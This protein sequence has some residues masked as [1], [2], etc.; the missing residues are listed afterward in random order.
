LNELV[1][2]GDLDAG[3]P[4]SMPTYD[5]SFLSPDGGIQADLEWTQAEAN[6]ENLTGKD[7]ID[8]TLS[9]CVATNGFPPFGQNHV[10]QPPA[11]PDCADAGGD[12]VYLVEDTTPPPADAAP[13]CDPRFAPDTIAA[14]LTKKGDSGNFT[15]VM[16]SA[17][18]LPPEPRYNTWIVKILDQN[19]KPVTDATLN[20]PNPYMPLHQHPTS[21]PSVYTSNSDGTYTISQFLF[22]A[23]NWQVTIKAK[24]G[25]TSDSVTF[26][27]C[28]GG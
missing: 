25:Q 7:G 23:G 22:M 8:S 1:K 14:G 19:G 10:A 4:A 12:D 2:S 24:S 17:L 13:A 28:A 5:V 15:F 21:I 11:P 16:A 27:F 9:T 20:L 6:A 18:P 3:V 26:E